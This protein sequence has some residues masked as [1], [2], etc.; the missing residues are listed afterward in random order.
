MNTIPLL[1]FC[2]DFITIPSALAAAFKVAEHVDIIE[3][4]TPLCKA[5]GMDAVRAVREIYPE[6]PILADMKTPDVGGLEAQLAFNAGA[7]LMT[8]MGGAPLATLES[9]MRVAKETGNEVLVELTGTGRQF[10]RIEDWKRLGVERV[11]YHRG[12]DE[13]VSNREW[14]QHDLVK[15]RGLI[16][17]GFKVS[18]AGGICVELLPLFKDLP[19][20]IIV[21]GRAIHQARDPIAAVRQLRA[22]IAS[23]WANH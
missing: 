17:E 5:A 22:T 23:F 7:N 1:Q 13:G 9:A 16:D 21:V 11:V 6:K 14:S 15:I 18:I 2:L 10:E 12:W 20:S 8:V 3:I 19:I 4:G